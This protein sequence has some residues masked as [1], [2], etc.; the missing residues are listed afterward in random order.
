[1]NLA[2]VSPN[3][4]N[5]HAFVFVLISLQARNAFLGPMNS[6]F[7]IKSIKLISTQIDSLQLRLDAY[8]TKL[9]NQFSAMEKIVSN[10]KSIGSYLDNQE[11]QAKKG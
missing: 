5:N 11:A 10:F 8:R 3:I 9:V 2:D 4:L 6:P 7:T 1:M